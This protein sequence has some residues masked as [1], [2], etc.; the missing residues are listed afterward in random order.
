MK[1]VLKFEFEG[2]EGFLSV[3]END[4]KYYALVQKDTSKVSEIRESHTLSISYDLKHPQYQ[5]VICNVIDDKML[6][7]WVYEELEKE[8]NLYFKE[9]DESL[10]VIE[11][12]KA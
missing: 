2:K 10:C 6:T 12:A 4:H 1:K 5:N 9:L 8:K 11:I 3:V 7:Q